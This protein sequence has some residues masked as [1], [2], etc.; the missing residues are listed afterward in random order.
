MQIVT[1][2]NVQCGGDSPLLLIAGPCQIEGLDHALSC[3][4]SL[5][6]MAADAGMGFVYKSSYDKANRTSAGAERGVG[7]TAP[8]V[9]QRHSPHTQVNTPWSGLSQRSP[10]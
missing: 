6:K 8:H 3:A 10:S 5:A 9:A 4:E 2:G 7:M 1:I